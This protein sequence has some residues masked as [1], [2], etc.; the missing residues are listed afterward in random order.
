[1]AV[2]LHHSR[3]TGTAKLVLLGIA[4][5]DGDGGAWPSVATLAHYANVA[6]RNV[7]KSIRHLEALGELRVHYQRGGTA[8]TLD[9]RRPNR[10]EPLVS[11]PGWCDRTAKHRDIRK[12]GTDAPLCGTDAPL[13]ITTGDASDTGD[14]SVTPRVTDATPLPVTPASPEPSIEPSINPTTAVDDATTERA[15]AESPRCGICGQPRVRC[16]AAAATNGHIYSPR[17]S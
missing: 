4:N 11:C 13:W 16:I 10:Y 8:E 15:H 7:K 3:A 17:A 2:V 12:R 14:A 9:A 6:P 5:H 1:M